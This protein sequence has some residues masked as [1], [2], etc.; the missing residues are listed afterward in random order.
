MVWD[1]LFRS[2]Y[3][4]FNFIIAGGGGKSNAG[5]GS[6]NRKGGGTVGGNSK[7]AAK[8]VGSVSV[9]SEAE[10]R[11][12]QKKMPEEIFRRYYPYSGFFGWK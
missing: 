10:K 6:A 12:M 7:Y 2:I 11:E 4:I 8:A 3:N 1:H 5:K 9:L